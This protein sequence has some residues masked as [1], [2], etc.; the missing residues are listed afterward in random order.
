MLAMTARLAPSTAM[1]SSRCGNAVRCDAARKNKRHQAHAARRGHEGELQRAPAEVDDLVD[2][3][4]GPHAGAED[5][6][7]QRTDQHAVFAVGKGS[8]GAGEGHTAILGRASAGRNVPR[9]IG[10][11]HGEHTGPAGAAQRGAHRLKLW[12]C[13][14]PGGPERRSY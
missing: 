5:G 14:P 10:S 13:P 9:G 12:P 4:H 11:S 8:K 1:I 6:D 3:G 2:H 7:G